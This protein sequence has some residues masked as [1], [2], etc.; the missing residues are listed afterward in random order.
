MSAVALPDIGQG[1]RAALGVV[2]LEELVRR[3]GVV[4]CAVL[5]GGVLAFDIE[6]ISAVGC[7]G[8]TR[9]AAKH[10]DETKL[11]HL[12]FP[13]SCSPSAEARIPR[14]ALLC[15]PRKDTK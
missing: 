3:R 9:R 7:R 13:R 5:E 15:Q 10:Q 11:F 4:R 12:K 6:R 2:R 1:E 14:Y 8:Q